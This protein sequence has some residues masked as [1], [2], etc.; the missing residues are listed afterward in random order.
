MVGGGWSR[1]SVLWG[2]GWEGR[3]ERGWWQG[4]LL[5]LAFR[6]GLLRWMLGV[7]HSIP[8]SKTVHQDGLGVRTGQQSCAIQPFFS[9]GFLPDWSFPKIHCCPGQSSADITC[10]AAHLWTRTRTRTN[11]LGPSGVQA[12]LL[13]KW[14]AWS[15]GGWSGS[16][17]DFLHD[18]PCGWYY[19]ISLC[20]CLK[21][22]S[23]QANGMKCSGHSH[24]GGWTPQ[25][26]MLCFEI[27]P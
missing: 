25:S 10:V 13:D 5:Q 7:P 14:W 11:Y 17:K 3:E 9:S 8:F 1:L 20:N 26:I 4:R 18:A 12:L 24:V 27:C 21:I 22:A 16:V 23:V 2:T 19:F 6:H 15:I